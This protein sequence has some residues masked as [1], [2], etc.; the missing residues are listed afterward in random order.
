MH[1]PFGCGID[2][3]SFGCL[4]F[5]FLTGT[6][7]F[8]VMMLGNSQHAQDEADDDHLLQL[9]NIIQPLPDSIMAAWSH[10]SMWFGPNRQQLAPFGGEPFIHEPL[11]ELFAQYKPDDIDDEESGVV[12]S[13]IRQ[14][15]DY[16][17]AKRPSAEDLLKHPW[18]SE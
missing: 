5:E 7:L 15:L 17:P 9:N 2:M 8:G 1:Q 18:F 11:E 16:N 3:W 10:A 13:L 12:C 6:P 4:L 14:I